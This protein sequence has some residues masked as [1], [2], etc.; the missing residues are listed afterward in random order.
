MTARN[1]IAGLLAVL[2]AAVIGAAGYVWKVHRDQATTLAAAS[3]VAQGGD[4][5][6]LRARPHLVFRSTALGEGYGRVAV[7]PL[8]DP[9]G[10]RA[11]TPVSCE[12]VHATGAGAV[13]LAAERGI[14]TTYRGRLLD[15]SWQPVRDLPLTGLPS[16]ARMSR[17]GSLVATTTFVFG[18]S[19]ANPGQFSTRTV[20][21]RTDGVVVGDIEKFTLTVNGRV[22]TAADKNLWGVTFLDDDTF[23]ATAASGGRTW[24]VKGSLTARTA[25]SVRGD[26]ECP[27]LSPDRTRVAFK[28]HGDLPAGKW[29]LAVLDLTTGVETELAE[30]RSVDDQAEWLDDDTVVYGLSRQD[31]GSAS[32][33]VWQVPA[34][35]TGEP[36]VLVGDAWSPAVVL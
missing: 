27:S 19:Y 36:E 10:P 14:V 35:G 8:S 20:V 15:T 6:S 9:G 29:R 22:V 34:D 13:C 33:D 32:S 25:T 26:V 17:D 5:A 7:V 24:L 23:Y 31:S 12:R 16:R 11:I 2:L 4:L 3:A 30:T 28:K 21:T 1:R 18:D